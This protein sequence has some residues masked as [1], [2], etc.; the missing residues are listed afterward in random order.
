MPL[1]L[2]LLLPL[3]LLRVRRTLAWPLP[4]LLLLYMV[5]LLLLARSQEALQ[6]C[7]AATAAVARQVCKVSSRQCQPHQGVWCRNN[8][9]EQNQSCC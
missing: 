6:C 1:L 2:L 8:A 3:L 9:L 4:L 7:T 5:L